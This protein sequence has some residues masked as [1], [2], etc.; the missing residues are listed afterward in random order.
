MGHKTRK[1]THKWGINRYILIKR[2][3]N[4]KPDDVHNNG[5]KKWEN[6]KSGPTY[7]LKLLYQYL[8]N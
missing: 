5:H 1:T 3:I 8:I 6:N 4:Q 7:R 2:K